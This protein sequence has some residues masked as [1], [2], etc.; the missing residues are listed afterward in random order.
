MPGKTLN[1]VTHIS[2][3]PEKNLNG[4]KT[5]MDNQMNISEQV[6]KMLGWPRKFTDLT[7]QISEWLETHFHH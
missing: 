5:L 2:E 4:E 7:K 1:T 6:E 3:Q